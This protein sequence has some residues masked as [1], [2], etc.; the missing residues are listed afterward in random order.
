[1]APWCRFWSTTNTWLFP[2]RV[3]GQPIQPAKFA[4]TLRSHQI[5]SRAAHNSALIN[6]ATDLPPAVLAHL[7]DLSI[8]VASSWAKYAKRD[9]TDYLAARHQD[10]RNT[11]HEE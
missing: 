10:G 9:W 8:G 4:R 2:G 1:M 6:L 7:L 5:V 3:P 11:A